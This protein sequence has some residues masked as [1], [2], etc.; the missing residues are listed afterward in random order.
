MG[1]LVF[2][3]TLGGQ[4]NLVGPNTASTFNLNVPAV[5][6]TLVTTGD[7]G[8]VT[9]TMLAGS[10][11][12]AKLS[13]SSVTIGGTAIALGA[14]SSTITNDLSISGLTVGKGGGAVGSNTAVGAN[15][16]TNSTGSSYGVTGFGYYALN[17]NTSGNSNVG[18]GAN[19]LTT[20]STG[21]SNV[22]VGHESLKLNTTASNN[23]AVGYQALY[24]NLT[25][26]GNTAVGQGAGYAVT[27]A[28]Q[29]VFVGKSAGIN[30]QTGSENTFVGYS[31]NGNGGTALSANT[32]IGRAALN[33]C[34]SN[35][36][37]AVGDG[38]L[39]NNTSGSQNTATGYNSFSAMT[40]GAGNTAIGESAGK[41]AATGNNSTFVGQNGSASGSANSHEIVI[42]CNTTGKGSNTGFI[43]P[44]GGG[45]YQGNN[46]A[47][48][49]IT[50]DQRL[51]KNI[52]DNTEGL[53]IVSQ[54]RV[55]NFEYRTAEEV[56]E[57]PAHTVIEKTGVQLGVIAQELQ[58]VCGDCVKTEST[59]VM[60]V[61]QDNITWHLV[62]AIKDLK[63]IVDAQAARI[64][65]LE[66]K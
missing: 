36:N 21:S 2:Q 29:N 51:K 45:V 13:N 9:N 48:W 57:L 16:V 32:G 19:A 60:S 12:N 54:I 61:N 15:A 8:T 35:Y 38:A 7:T 37:T 53:D 56:T 22:A 4:V 33:N 46:S 43:Q 11:A 62:N 3:A 55:R 30:I 23:T 1:Q 40:T 59:G 17:G 24:N 41:V 63:T 42:G 25:A 20:N 6:G 39:Q 52:V 5:A 50:S 31:A 58:E 66:A 44:N 27:T 26:A 47:T 34:T 64:A 14:S 10:I 49:S 28:D 18:I 65:T